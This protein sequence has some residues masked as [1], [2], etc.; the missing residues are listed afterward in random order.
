MDTQTSP[1]KAP[2]TGAKGSATLVHES[3]AQRQYIRL[4]LPVEVEIEG[5]RYISEDW[6]GGGLS[7]RL[8]EGPHPLA[9]VGVTT[10]AVLLFK[11]G[12]FDINVPVELEVR[13]VIGSRIGCRF[14]NVGTAQLSLLQFI[15]HAYV[16]GEVVRVGDI[17]EIVSRNNT[18]PKRALPAGG[19]A[20]AKRTL[21]W[22]LALAASA[23][24][25][26]Y[27]GFGV[28]ER[29]FVVRSDEAVVLSE[30]MVVEAPKS[31]RLFYQPITPGKPVAKGDPLL[32]VQT[33][34]GNMESV[35]SPC[36]CVVRERLLDNYARVHTGEPVLRLLS[37]DS[38]PYVQARVP[39]GEALRVVPGASAIVTVPGKDGSVPGRVVSQVAEES[40]NGATFL[41]VELEEKLAPETIGGS[42]TV[43]IRTNRV[44]P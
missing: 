42:A 6:S 40:K 28:W 12:T 9:Q 13:N 41:Y 23:L 39:A 44:A 33:V 27:I 10:K 14:S 8:P 29:A 35:D 18:A 17:I 31:G 22:T 25:I 34:N 30:S 21:G 19:T 7:L 43:R 15:V 5:Q 16:T 3:E 36:N 24:L 38:N 32:M 4:Q 37:I 20:P 2:D 26:T 11:F 1:A